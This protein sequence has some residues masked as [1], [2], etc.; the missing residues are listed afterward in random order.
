MRR[1]WLEYEDYYEGIREKA[2]FES[3]MM[4]EEIIGNE[5]FRHK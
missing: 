2:W 4:V 1:N 3:L 5:I